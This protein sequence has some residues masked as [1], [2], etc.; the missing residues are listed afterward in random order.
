MALL[1]GFAD[2]VGQAQD[3]QPLLLG[4]DGLSVDPAGAYHGLEDPDGSLT[5]EEV[6]KALANGKFKPIDPGYTQVGHT[7]SVWWVY[8]A[9]RSSGPRNDWYLEYYTGEMSRVNLWVNKGDGWLEHGI[10]GFGIPPEQRSVNRYF[11]VFP[12]PLTSNQNLEILTRNTSRNMDLQMWIARSEALEDRYTLDLLVR[13]LYY[14]VVFGVLFYNLLLWVN[15]RD[16]TYLYYCFFSATWIVAMTGGAGLMDHYL[17]NEKVKFAHHTTEFALL[18]MVSATLFSRAFLKT[19]DNIPRMDKVLLGF[20]V[21]ISLFLVVKLLFLPAEYGLLVDGISFLGMIL[22]TG[23]G[24]KVWRQGYSP[25]GI[26]VLAWGVF[27]LFLTLWLLSMSNILPKVFITNYG[28]LIGN[29]AEIA[30]MSWALASRHN[31]IKHDEAEADRLR[32]LVRI[33]CHDFAN[34][35]SVIMANADIA[36][37]MVND[38]KLKKRLQAIS[39]GGHH[40]D[41]LIVHIRGL[42]ALRSGKHQLEL[43]PVDLNKIFSRVEDTFRIRLDDK[44][45]CLEFDG[46]NGIAV[47]AEAVSLENNVMNNLISNAIKFSL[48]G[49]TITITT[50]LH[51]KNEVMISVIDRGVGIPKKLIEKLFDTNEATT[52]RVTEKERGTGFGMPLVKTTLDHYH[53]RIEVLSKDVDI[54]PDDSGT[55]I[56]I[57]LTRAERDNGVGVSEAS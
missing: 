37:N 53:G 29:G 36:L 2:G 7:S 26:W 12:L 33:L 22:L 8:L 32:G 6:K 18:T 56:N 44:E 4:S 47:L 3:I 43:G 31:I 28:P 39:R 42:E 5:L 1:L 46:E 51:G 30:I 41:E 19:K 23:A 40:L 55:C 49:Q 10:S 21:C 14:G 15:L 13:G 48:R 38:P 45:L 52:R 20:L 50:S 16:N 35:I 34:P 11:P 57:I 25:A 9:V 24:V 17:F 54:H 27:F